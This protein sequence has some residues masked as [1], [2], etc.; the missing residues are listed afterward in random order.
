VKDEPETKVA[1]T[2]IIN[3]GHQYFTKDV[4]KDLELDGDTIST[5]STNVS[6]NNV[7]NNA[8]LRDNTSSNNKLEEPI[9]Q[10]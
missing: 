4:A 9:L 6:N 2:V 3:Q 1:D 8:S 7:N 5:T 10:Q